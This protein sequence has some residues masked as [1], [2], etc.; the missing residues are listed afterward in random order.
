MDINYKIKPFWFWNGNMEDKQIVTQIK[1]MNEKGIG[2]FFIHP[3]QG[4]NIPYLSDEWFK[5]VSI[6]VETAKRYNMEVWLYDEYPYPSGI[7]AGE[8]IARNPEYQAFIL[9]YKTKEISF[10][11]E[12]NIE[13]PLSDILF[14]GAYQINDGLINWNSFVD[15]SDRIGI[16]YKDHIYQESGLTHYNKKRYFTGNPIKVLRWEAPSGKWRLFVFYQYPLKEFKFFGTFIDP[17]NK[18]AIKLFIQLTHEKYKKYLGHEFGKTIKGIYTDETAPLGGK[19]PWSKKIAPIFENKYGYNLIENL[20]KLISN[21]AFDNSIAEIR[22]HFWN[23][24]VD[25]FI[26]S[27]DKQIFNWCHNNNLLYV[28]EKPIL[29]SSQLQYMDVPGIDAGHQK[30]GD[31]PMIISENYRANPKIASSAA[32][33]YKKERTLCECFHS[34]G[35]SMTI[36]DM[37]WIYDWLIEQGINMFVPHAFYYSANGLKK[38]DAPPSEFLQMPWWQNQDV[39]SDYVSK[40]TQIL[41]NFKRKVDILLLDPIQTQWTFFVEEDIRKKYT[42]DF[43]KLQEYLLKNHIDYYVVDQSLI[44]DFYAYE[45]NICYKDEKYEIMIIPPVSNIE[46]QAWEKIEDLILNGCKIIFAGCMP[47]QNINGMDFTNKIDALFNIDALEIAHKYLDS[48]NLTT[49]KLNYE[50]YFVGNIEDISNIIHKIYKNYIEI[51]AEK[52]E[53]RILSTLYENGSKKLLFLVNPTA[54]EEKCIL[55]L[56]KMIINFKEFN[57]KSILDMEDI[58]LHLVNNGKEEIS[59]NIKFLP[60]QS[61]LLMI[62]AESNEEQCQRNNLFKQMIDVDSIWEINLDRLN[63]L[64]IDDWRLKVQSIDESNVVFESKNSI[65]AKPIIDQIEESRIPVLITTKSPFGCAKELLLS[66]LHIIYESSF[67][68]NIKDNE[69]WL[70]IEEESIKGDWY[71]ELNGHKITPYEFQVRKF[72]IENNLTC[73]ISRYVNVGE[74]VIKV[75]VCTDKPYDGLLTPIY[76]FG[77]IGVYE[78]ENKWLISQSS[79][80]GFFNKNV[81]NGIPFF[82]GTISYKKKINISDLPNDINYVRFYLAENVSDSISM[83]INDYFIGTRCWQPYFWDVPYELIKGNTI[84]LR[85][86]VKTTLLALFEGEYIDPKTHTILPAIKGI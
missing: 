56:N 61:Y 72:Y 22:Y 25:T 6:A 78:T 15:L 7:A 33:F 81:K 51:L 23:V 77:K 74:N 4:L 39:L 63:P 44:N 12:V 13:L 50:C 52:G 11:E 46:R 73:E 24:V 3:R 68:S 69:L 60:Y 10:G 66:P 14:A 2:G 70:V 49:I 65:H 45:G 55:K 26:N 80:V 86:D 85:L 20:P 41:S 58:N 36:Q 17:L 42:K 75:N 76:I 53:C 27:Y 28:G 59:F 1:E 47:F 29:R 31:N 43:Y 67:V 8:V 9:D 62:E 35:W 34:I 19:I 71:I 30:A 5:K 48:Q 84:V 18:D 82:A 38:H 57:I 16:I 54:Y 79:S 40:L 83:Y 32:H 21:G 64:R 37:K